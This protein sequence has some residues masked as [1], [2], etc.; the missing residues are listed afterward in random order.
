MNIKEQWGAH[1]THL[2]NFLFLCVLAAL[3]QALSVPKGAR[4]SSSSLPIK[5]QQSAIV[6]LFLS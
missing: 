2:L 1:G 4:P 5:N 3:P 6:N